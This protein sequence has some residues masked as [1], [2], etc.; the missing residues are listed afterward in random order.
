MKILIKTLILLSLNST[1]LAAFKITLDPGHGGPDDSG[2]SYGNVKESDL[3]LK[4]TKKLYQKLKNDSQFD[5]Q[6]LRLGDESLSLENRVKISQRFSPDLFLSIHANAHTNNKA[7][8]A[9]FYI[10]NQLPVDEESLFLAHNE[11]ENEERLGP[12]NAGDVESIIY[13]LEKSHRITESYH[14]S[15]FLRKHWTNKKR[16]MIRQGPFYVLSHNDVPAILI[17][18]GYLSHSKERKKLLDDEL[19][20]KMVRKIHK[21]LKDYATNMDK[22]PL[23]I[24][25]PGNAKT[26]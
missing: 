4:I 3:V 14:A 23:S 13:D 8:G 6:I 7:F 26:R 25:Q 21:A 1:C 22:T 17:E 19:Q 16:K 2:A 20:N 5:V 9:E 18:V 11:F 10:Q 24:L 15:T 12:K